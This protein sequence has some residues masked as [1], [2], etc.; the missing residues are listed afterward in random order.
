MQTWVEFNFN[1]GL[2]TYLRRPLVV[3]FFLLCLP[4]L[5][6]CQTGY[7]QLSAF[8]NAAVADNHSQII[9]TAV[10]TDTHGNA[11]PDGTEV[12]FTTDLGSFQ[13]TIVTTKNGYAHGTLIAGGVAGVA[14]ITVKVVG[15]IIPPATYPIKFVR[16]RDD[17]S[18][19]N[20][21]AKLI[22]PGGVEYDPRSQLIELLSGGSDAEVDYDGTIITGEKIQLNPQTMEVHCRRATLTL[23]KVKRKF[24]ELNYNLATNRGYALGSYSS[25]EASNIILSWPLFPPL[26][27][28]PVYQQELFGM[29]SIVGDETHGLNQNY[30][31]YLFSIADFSQLPFIFTGKS[32][33]L[34][35]HQE[36]DFQHFAYDVGGAR[37]FATPLYRVSLTGGALP[38]QSQVLA[39]NDNQLAISYPYYLSLSPEQTSFLRF[40]LGDEGSTG[41]GAGNGPQFDYEVDW[42]K[43]PTNSGGVLLNGIGQSNWGLG[44]HQYYQLDSKSS[45]FA[46]V[47]SP[48]FK[49]LFGAVSA[50]RQIGPFNLSLA[51]NYTQTLTGI[52]ET[53]L[54]QSL[55]L[56]HSPIKLGTLPVHLSYG[57]SATRQSTSLPVPIQSQAGYGLTTNF[58]LDPARLD[59]AT[60]FNSSLQV[61]DFEGQNVSKGLSYNLLMSLSHTLSQSS[62]LF[63]TY[64]YSQDPFISSQFGNQ[65][66]STT[67]DYSKGGG[68]FNVST[69]TSLG[70]NNFNVSAFA[71]YRFAPKWQFQS[72]Y[73][74]DEIAGLGYLDYNLTLLY[75]ISGEQV[76]LTWSRYTGRL[77]IVVLGT[78]LF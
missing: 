13:Q 10:A 65:R 56:L 16:T 39:V 74:E 30:N 35:P 5:S 11:V 26:F 51:S 50:N 62:S 14:T 41:Y 12:E 32:A 75:T 52:K 23:G 61:N 57:L 47:Q 49:S 58:E 77:G 53:D 69:G 37:T 44:F 15:L 33:V 22:G 7:V 73:T 6:Y 27:F 8:P 54:S 48:Q 72:G 17:L 31:K 40:H 2:R 4:I 64:S 1:L 21:Y 67:F 34:V 45:I 24:P 42:K 66:V 25:F 46:Q 9:I 68:F 55:N 29:V 59:R 60:T 18:S 76:G 70:F 28:V 71:G 3:L 78:P 63:L 38:Y 19:L 43:G 36:V 20:D